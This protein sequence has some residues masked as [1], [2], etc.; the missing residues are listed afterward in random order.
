MKEERIRKFDDIQNI[1]CEEYIERF[2][3]EKNER[4]QNAPVDFDKEKVDLEIKESLLKKPVL[5][6][7]ISQEEGEGVT[8]D[9]EK[10][11]KEEEEE[12]KETSKEKEIVNEEGQTQ[13]E[14]KKE[15]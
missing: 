14:D 15:E 5:N 12:E 2:E 3:Q 8:S 4:L 11:G 6:K 1:L 7:A 9:K 10:E 13:E